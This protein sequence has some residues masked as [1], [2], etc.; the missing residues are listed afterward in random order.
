MKITQ[1]LKHKYICLRQDGFFHSRAFLGLCVLL[2]FVSIATAGGILYNAVNF[3]TTIN[4]TDTPTATY[5]VTIDGTPTPL[6]ITETLDL[7]PDSFVEI[8]YEIK[9][10]ETFPLECEFTYSSTSGLDV[11][12][13]DGTHSETTILPLPANTMKHFTIRYT[14]DDTVSDGDTLT[15]EINCMVTTP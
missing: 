5:D 14:T 6:T 15:A 1:K 9:N 3:E 8:E 4:V 2:L 11:T 7:A 13:Y 10:L 12:I